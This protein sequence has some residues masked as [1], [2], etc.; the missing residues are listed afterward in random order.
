MQG[1]NSRSKD[2]RNG[3]TFR[4]RRKRYKL[5]PGHPTDQELIASYLEND[6][7]ITKCPPGRAIGSLQSQSFGL[8]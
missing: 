3:M 2:Q 5:R 4:R 8:E 6:G 1:F 7:K